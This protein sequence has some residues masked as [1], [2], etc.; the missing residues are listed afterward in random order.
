MV[1]TS[2]S[3]ANLFPSLLLDQVRFLF[4]EILP[5]FVK[6]TMALVVDWHNLSRLTIKQSKE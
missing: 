2:E 3:H 5:L 6:T 1:S 4:I